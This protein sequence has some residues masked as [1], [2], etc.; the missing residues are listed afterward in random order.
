MVKEALA[1][2][3]VM[4]AKE[5]VV[6]RGRF[7]LTRLIRNTRRSMAVSGARVDRVVTGEVV[8]VAMEDH[9]TA[10]SWMVLAARHRHSG[11]AKIS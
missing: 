10:S 7:L 1:A 3:A 11:A 5:V 9:L 8:L 4:V 6:V 2:G